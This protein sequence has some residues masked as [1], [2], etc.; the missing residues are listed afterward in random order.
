VFWVHAGT[1]ARFE[2][3]YRRIAEATKMR[4]W[5]DPKADVLRLVRSWL[6]NESNGRWV[7]VVDNADDADVFFTPPLGTQAAS[8][9]RL[10]QAAELLSDFLPQSPSGSIVVTSRS[11]D[12]AFRLTGSYDTIFEVRPMEERDALALLQ[13]KLLRVG[14]E[15][16]AEKARELVQA[17]D[18]MP[19]AITQAAAYIVQRSPRTSVARYLDD[20]RRSDYDRARL[21]KKDV[22]DSRRDGRASNSIIATWQIS[23]EHIRQEVPAAA[24]LLSLMSLFDRQGIPE[25]LL[26]DQ[27]AADE[28][29]VDDEEG[30]DFDDDINT[31]VSY[32]LV[33]MSR[34]DGSEFEMHRLVQYSTKKWL[35]LSGELEG[36]KERYVALMDRSYPVGRHANWK[37]CQALFP[38]AQAAA[39][40]RPGNAEV[41]ALEAWAS[42]LYKAAWYADE[43]GQYEAAR[44]M[45]QSALEV[46][47]K[48]LGHEH[49]STLASMN[50]L[51]G[52]LDSQG[53]YEEAE[54][55]HR[56]T[57]AT[58]EKVLG[59][60][61]PS[62]L[63]SM[64]NLA[65]VLD[66]Q[67]KY[68]EAEA[69]HRQELAICEKVLGREHPSTLMS[70][71]NLA[72]VLNSQ[73]KY[74]E[75]EAMN[76]QTL[77]T[78]EK[79]LG[80]EH[81]D[82]LASMNNLAGVLDSQ[83]K[84]EEAEAMHRQTLAMRE[85][86]LGREHPDTLMSMNNLA[87]VLDSQGKHEE[88]E[89]MHRQTLA[90]REKVLGHEHPDTLT[91]MSNLATVLDRQGKYDEAEAM[92][93]QTLAICEKVLG[94]E[95][96]DTLTSM[97]NLATVLDRQGKY[98]EAEAMHRQTLAMREKALGREHPST[99]T[100]VYCLAYLLA[101]EHMFEES[102][103]LYKRA[104]DG[105]SK[106]LGEHH[107][108]TRACQQ[109]RSE[110]VKSQEQS[111]VVFS[112]PDKSVSAPTRKVSRLSRGLAH[113]GIGGSKHKKSQESST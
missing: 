53:K 70:M 66:R 23:F 36:W 65:G 7:M 98:E 93:R 95:H 55:M 3:G 71:N 4:G 75:A 81:P 89:A 41:K 34:A 64:N 29:K 11:R 111:P 96:P 43:M 97:N 74:D 12:V 8:A 62:T 28:D 19:L 87:S 31:L 49:P 84:Y 67:G 22:G 27:Y 33:E 56:Q 58:K 61:H 90:T 76:R 107:P 105:Y 38:H 13:K 48:V 109:H 82:T 24:R 110:V 99:L 88:A 69:M 79:V 113:L 9:A 17:L 103:N 94:R 18:R 21:L 1:Q 44:E 25:S 85:E 2:Q 16:D 91:S 46:R 86:V 50:N 104:C 32:S 14:A 106:V 54:A 68:E 101:K 102:L 35:E 10:S 57:L 45:N 112:A 63:T 5:A 92:H 52:V 77:A 42:V 30:A 37:V 20:I 6:C 15:T 108:T 47:E 59:R 39:D 51:A 80:R 26:H 40:S 83:G 78:R 100:S 73:G 72:T 60:E